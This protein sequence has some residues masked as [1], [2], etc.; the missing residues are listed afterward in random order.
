M[1][2]VFMIHVSRICNVMEI[3]MKI[4]LRCVIMQI[5]WQKLS[6]A[7]FK[8]RYW[9]R[10]SPQ[11]FS[12]RWVIWCLGNDSVANGVRIWIMDVDFLIVCIHS[13]G[14]VLPSPIL[15]GVIYKFK[16]M[17]MYA[18]GTKV[19]GEA[20]FGCQHIQSRQ[21]NHHFC[22]WC[23]IMLWLVN[24]TWILCSSTHIFS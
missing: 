17:L 10:N 8:I 6:L 24:R 12:Y 23:D 5:R 9:S 11:C 13:N 4:I 16:Y 21:P 15:Y 1:T 14:H 2:W 7:S 19:Y 22:K 20:T 3:I 18:W